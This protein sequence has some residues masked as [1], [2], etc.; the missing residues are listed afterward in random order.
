MTTST[1][2]VHQFTVTGMTCGHCEKSVVQ[3][4]KLLDPQAQ[5]QADRTQN[6]VVVHSTQSRDALA[7]AIAE[8]GY[9]VAPAH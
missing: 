3:A 4:V 5:V 6:Q 2:P 8:E 7:A 9:T 1:T